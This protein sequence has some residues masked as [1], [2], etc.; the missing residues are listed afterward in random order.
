VG[1]NWKIPISSLVGKL[2]PAVAETMGA[3]TVAQVKIIDELTTEVRA[4]KFANG[5]QVREELAKRVAARIAA[6]RPATTPTTKPAMLPT[7]RH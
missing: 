1:P 6:T 2:N 5:E 7:T 3:S 4:G